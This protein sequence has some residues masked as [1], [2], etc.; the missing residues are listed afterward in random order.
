LSNIPTVTVATD[1]EV[2]SFIER[3]ALFGRGIGFMDAHL[4]ASVLLTEGA[5]LWTFDRSLLALAEREE[6]AADLPGRQT[7]WTT[8]R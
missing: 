3:R 5:K 2:F 6:C 8:Q 1:G 7:N 4:L